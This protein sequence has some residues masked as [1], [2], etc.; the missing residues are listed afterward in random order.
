MNQERDSSSRELVDAISVVTGVFHRDRVDPLASGEQRG[1]PRRA[2][3]RQEGRAQPSRSFTTPRLLH[4]PLLALVALAVALSGCV[5]RPL[6]S[7]LQASTT[8]ITPDGDGLGD[9][10]KIDYT[11]GQRADVSAEIIGPDG[12]TYTLRERHTRVPDDYQLTFKGSIDLPD[13]TERRVLPD[14]DYTIVVRANGEDG[15][16]VEQRLNVSIANA[17]T[18]PVEIRDFNADREEITPNGDAEGDEVKFSYGLSKPATT[19][20]YVTDSQG[21][22][23]LIEEPKEKEATMSAHIWDGKWG[24]KVLPNGEYTLHVEAWD[25]A[26]NRT[27]RTL[28]LRINDGG[29]PR[30]EIVDVKFSPTAISVGNKLNVRITVR[31][32][33]TAPIKTFGPPSTDEYQYTTRMSYASFRDPDNPDLPLFFERAGFFRV[34][35]SWT[36]A[37]QN[38]PVRWSLFEDLNRVL[39]PGEEVT[40]TGSITMLET[41]NSHEL[42]FWAG[43][44]QEGV[45]FPGGQVGHTKVTIGF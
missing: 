5:N 4:W 35:V 45:G 1:L 40:I 44:I 26:G 11:I 2:S 17:D 41:P 31:N 9:E 28:P 8:R 25:Q 32:T 29:V 10:L 7:S 30:L 14:G 42:T 24:G 36:N 34:G 33:G 27:Q 19:Q 16:T 39:Q 23:Y 18:N 38:Y 13:S 37:P 43:V 20:V 15:A 3:P 6:L 22:H 12:K 21:G